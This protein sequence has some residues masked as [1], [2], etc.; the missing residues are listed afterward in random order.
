MWAS[1]FAFAVSIGAFVLIHSLPWSPS[2]FFVPAI[3][4]G[5]AQGFSMPNGQAAVVSH[6]P[7]LAGTASGLSGFLQ[8]G[9]AAIFAQVVGMSQDGTPY[10]TIF[11]MMCA[12]GLSFAAILF[13]FAAGK[14][15]GR[16]AL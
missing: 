5:F 4:I 9:T 14:R 8:M 10:P 7:A 3:L 11:V 1:G 16:D 13:G 2:L 12:A 15:E 6:D